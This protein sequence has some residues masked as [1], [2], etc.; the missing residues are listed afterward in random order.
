MGYFA[1]ML[2]ATVAVPRAAVN[3]TLREAKACAVAA[4]RNEFDGD[5]HA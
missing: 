4:R 2:G 5:R 1:W 3:A